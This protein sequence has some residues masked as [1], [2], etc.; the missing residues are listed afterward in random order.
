MVFLRSL[1]TIVCG[2]CVGHAAADEPDW[3][4]YEEVLGRQIVRGIS[5]GVELNQVDY[6]GL[7]NEPEFPA[8]V[9]QVSEFPLARL[10]TREET[11]AFYINAYNI[12][13]LKM[14]LDNRPLDSITDIGNVFKSVW[15]R[16]A[17][18]LDG[19]PVS[20]DDIEH[21]RLRTMNEPR[22]H[23]AIVCASVSCPDLRAEA[24]R[25]AS[26]EAQLDAQSADFLNNP[27]K[28]LK[29]SGTRAQVSRIFRWFGDDFAAVGGVEAFVR[30]YYPLPASVR[31]RPNLHYNWSLNGR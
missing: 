14:V 10:T 18:S 31:L 22:V 25:A 4:A 5:A 6:D 2:V 20:L 13:A 15:K 28:G 16:N 29:L 17:G 9:R 7:A 27:G 24:Y 11:L 19:K 30:R 3:Q 23:F 12:F 26:L 8:I 1:I 21:K